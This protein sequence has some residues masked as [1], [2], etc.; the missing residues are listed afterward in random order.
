MAPSLS[1]G[2]RVIEIRS[3]E[4]H[5]CFTI[6]NSDDGGLAWEIG[7]L[8]YEFCK[9]GVTRWLFNQAH[10]GYKGLLSLR[11]RICPGLP[12]HHWL[13]R[14]S[15]NETR[16]RQSFKGATGGSGEGR[17]APCEPDAPQATMVSTG[18]LLLYLLKQTGNKSKIAQQK[19]AIRILD[20]LCAL[21]AGSC[22]VARGTIVMQGAPWF[23]KEFLGHGYLFWSGASFF[24]LF[25]KCPRH[26]D[27]YPGAIALQRWRCGTPV[28]F[29][30]LVGQR[31]RASRSGPVRHNIFHAWCNL[32]GGDPPWGFWG[33]LP[34]ND[35]TRFLHLN[36]DSF[37][38]WVGAVGAR[39]ARCSDTGLSFRTPRKPQNI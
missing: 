2:A 11:C 34:T 10:C 3:Q 16:R 19:K 14:R 37:D 24:T 33:Q 4:L 29:A 35:L 9:T 15:E 39:S 32:D 6:R 36:V 17:R 18:F 12:V 38:R 1:G 8:H 23:K 27:I 30:E 22:D 25:C 31:S 5:R 26:F 13:S 28:A 20:M 21:C 7:P